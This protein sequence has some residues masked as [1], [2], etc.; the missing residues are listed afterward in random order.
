MGTPILGPH[1]IDTQQT[2]QELIAKYKKG[3]QQQI[4]L[5]WVSLTIGIQNF[6]N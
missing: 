3:T 6:T 2:Y 4:A 5:I 1:S